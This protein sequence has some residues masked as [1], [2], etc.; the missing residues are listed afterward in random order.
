MNKKFFDLKLDIIFRNLFGNEKHEEVIRSFIADL[1]EIPAKNI[2]NI[3]VGSADLSPE[4]MGSNLVLD[5]DGD[6]YKYRITNK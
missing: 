5:I 2:R 4:F 1:L 6:T 3:S